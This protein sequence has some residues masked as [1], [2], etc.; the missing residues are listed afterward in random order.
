M[1]KIYVA[2]SWRNVYQPVVVQILRT[3]GHHVYDFRN[4]APNVGGFS[5]AEIDP[6]WQHWSASDFREALNHDVA[7]N[8]FRYDFDGMAGAD[9]CVLVLPCGRS[10]HLEAGWFMG[11]GKP[12]V[13][14]APER[15]EPELMYMLASHTNPIVLGFKE[16]LDKVDTIDALLEVNQQKGWYVDRDGVRTQHL[17][18]RD[19]LNDFHSGDGRVVLC[20]A[21]G[22]L[23]AC[24]S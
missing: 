15:I 12:V 6:N 1:A 16:M 3:K 10:A 5:W 13:V 18:W 20:R 14:L 9:L 7:R 19:A 21:N 22:T 2:S 8:G 4:P 24:R 11:K 23:L 17:V